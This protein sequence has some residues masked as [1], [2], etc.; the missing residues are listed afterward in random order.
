MVLSPLTRN[1]AM[2]D[3]DLCVFVSNLVNFMTRDATEFAV[4]AVDTADV[5]AFKALGDAFEIRPTDEWYMGNVAIA[6]EDKNAKADELRIS[7]RSISVRAENKWGVNSARYRQFGVTGMNKFNDRDLLANARNVHHTATQYLADLAS[8]GLTAP[9]LTAFQTLTNEFESCMND[10]SDA[11]AQRSIKTEERITKGNELYALTVKYCNIGKQSFESTDPA[12]YNDYIIYA[13]GG[14]GPL[15]APTNFIYD[16]PSNTFSWS[17][18]VNATSY[19]IE[20]S[21]NGTDWAEI[22]ADVLESF[23]YIPVAGQTKHYRVRA[24]NLAGF[25]PYSTELTFAYYD[26][27]ATPTNLTLSLS[28][29]AKPYLMGLNWNAVPGATQYEVFRSIVPVGEPAGFFTFTQLVN[30]NYFSDDANPIHRYYFYVIAKN[31]YL[32]SGQSGEVFMDLM[33]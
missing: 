19:Q 31:S 6:T 33:N 26:S 13:T 7:I 32:Q 8:E 2:S 15:V 5:T 29:I 4:Y 12:K 14:G 1:Y 24:R 28:G 21:D 9:I 18:V 25:G 20:S 10:Q 30:T 22:Y 3:A 23:I 27:L 11:I 16:F 17:P